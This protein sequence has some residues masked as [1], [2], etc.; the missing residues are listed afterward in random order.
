M[1]G[2]KLFSVKGEWKMNLSSLDLMFR[3]PSK[4]QPSGPSIAHIFV[5][6]YSSNKKGDIF[7]TPDC[8]SMKELEGQIDRLK[9]ELETIKKKAQQEFAKTGQTV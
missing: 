5:R 6:T 8:F 7:I 3:K 4:H 2:R 9:K 1:A